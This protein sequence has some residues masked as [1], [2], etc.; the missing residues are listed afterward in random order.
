MAS[1]YRISHDSGGESEDLRVERQLM[2]LVTG[3][4]RSQ[5]LYAAA[6]LGIADALAKGIETSDNLAEALEAHP[7]TMFRLLR[8]LSSL[9]I[10]AQCPNGAFALTRLGEGLKTGAPGM[11]RSRAI[12]NCEEDYQAWGNI[13]YTMKTGRPG[14]EKAYGKG[15]WEYLAEDSDMPTIFSDSMFGSAPERYELVAQAYDFSQVGSVADIGGG[16]GGLTI[17]ILRANPHL[18]GL[19]YDQPAV[20]SGTQIRINDAGLSDRCK[21]VSGSF[22]ESVPSGADVYILS[23]VLPDW[24]DDKAAVILQNIREAMHSKSRLLV[25]ARL[26]PPDDTPSPGKMKDLYLLIVVGG[27]ERT[28]EE[29]SRLLSINGFK[30]ANIHPGDTEQRIIEAVPS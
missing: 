26:I 14:F 16:Y 15:Y 24:T 4:R 23:R 27:Q 9:G 28:E 11:V 19:I 17:S 13:L 18:K 6:K 5:V 12:M 3:Y 8:A 20:T 30:I 21:V 22:F 25:V 10:V 2:D 1:E 29:Y 7:L